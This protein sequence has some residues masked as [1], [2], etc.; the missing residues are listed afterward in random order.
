MLSSE[1]RVFEKSDFDKQVKT[2]CMLF[3]QNQL[4]KGGVAKNTS[5]RLS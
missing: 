5:G 3:L 4:A 1:L 2:S